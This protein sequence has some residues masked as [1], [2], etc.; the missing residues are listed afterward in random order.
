MVKSK[1]PSSLFHADRDRRRRR[2][3]DRV[4]THHQRPAHQDR[5]TPADSEHQGAAQQQPGNLEH[6]LHHT[7]R[8][9]LRHREPAPKTGLR[10]VRL[11]L[12]GSITT[13]SACRRRQTSL[14]ATQTRSGA[15]V[16]ARL[17]IDQHLLGGGDTVNGEF[18]VD[19]KL[20]LEQGEPDRAEFVVTL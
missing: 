5:P 1:T 15:P 13:T 12:D 4:L 16:Q 9:S 17:G 3:R 20:A 10:H 2:V 18:G 8:A 14:P 11:A 19:R 6:S 7:S